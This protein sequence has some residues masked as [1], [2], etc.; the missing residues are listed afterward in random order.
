MMGRKLV[1]GQFGTT[2][3]CTHKVTGGR[4]ACKFI[5]KWKLLC[6]EDYDDVWREIQIMHHLSEHPHVVRIKGTY[7]DSYAFHLIMELALLCPNLNPII[8]FRTTL[9]IPT[10]SSLL[11][12]HFSSSKEHSFT[13]NYLVKN[14]GFSPETASRLSNRVRLNNSDR[15]DSVLALFRSHGFSNAQLCGIIRTSPNLLTYDPNKTI[16][17]KFNFLLS[18]GASSS[19]LVHIVTKNPTVLHSSLENTISPC[20]D[21]VKRFRLSDESTLVSIKASACLIY[22]KNLTQNIQLLLDNGVPES[23]VALFFRVRNGSYTITEHH[24]LF[25]KAVEEVKELGINPNKSIFIVAV[26][27]KIKKECVWERRINLYKK[28]GWSEEIIVSAFVRYPWCMLAYDNK[29]EAVMEFWVN[30]MGWSS[31][32]LAKHPLL[33]TLSLEKRVIPRALVLQFLQARGLIKDAKSIS[34]YT[35]N[36]KKFLQKFVNCFEEEA[37]QLLKLYE[38]KNYLPR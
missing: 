9:P 25:K 13:F 27:A 3:L 23:K 11:L 17:P 31:L 26:R 18:K 28:W 34:Y 38:G 4:C 24:A 10:P 37:S 32:I 12:Q 35:V 29:I 15:P 33:I 30:H 8:R 22:S 5:L 19:D 21:L 14:C 1:H 2:Y 7:E 36:E 6:K 20:Y 16:L